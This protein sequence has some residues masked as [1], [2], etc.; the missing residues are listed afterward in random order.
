M[1]KTYRTLL[2]RYAEDDLVEIIDYYQINNPVY[3]EKLLRILENKINELKKYPE[4]GRVVPE[5]EDQNI[6]EY[7][8]S[9]EGYYRIIYAI[10]DNTVVIHTILDGRRDLEELLISKLMRYYS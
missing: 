6:I 4:R 8:E 5:L 9:I 3:A 7:R 10:Q 1:S 2:S